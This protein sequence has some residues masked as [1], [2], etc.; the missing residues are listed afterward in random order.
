MKLINK[1]SQEDKDK[2]QRYISGWRK[3][4]IEPE[5]IDTIDDYL[6]D[7]G[8]NLHITF[9]VGIPIWDYKYDNGETLKIWN[10][11]NMWKVSFKCRDKEEFSQDFKS[12]KDL[13]KFM[14]TN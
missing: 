4:I 12:A 5:L 11:S 14:E 10:A 13:I 9:S 7:L 8:F 6:A 1:L 2:L 3:F